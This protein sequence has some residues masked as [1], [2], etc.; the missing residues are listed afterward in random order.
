MIPTKNVTLIG[1][2]RLSWHLGPALENAHY[3][4]KEVYSRNRKNAE[5][6]VGR[7]YDAEVADTLDFAS[8]P[9][10]LFVLAV[11]DDAIASV[12]RELVLPDQ[13]ILV[14]TSGAKP[15]DV[16]D[17]AGTANTGVFYP[18]Q[19]FSKGHKVD[20]ESIPIFIESREPTVLG[21]LQRMARALSN[22]VI[23]IQS[24]QRLALHVAAVF[25]SN[26]TNHML[27]LSK[28]I[29]SQNSLDY[30]WMHPLIIETINKSLAQG[31]AAAQTGPARRRDLETLDL[32]YEFLDADPELRELYR[33][34][35]QHIL[36]YYET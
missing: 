5:A 15:L 7:L 27:S 11:S 13:S 26:F 17:F 36:D 12:A 28:D 8:S 30:Q 21:E 16:L 3:P 1:S 34:V 20:F 24:R 23:P 10:N 14:H 29:M 2:G 18:L 4:V 9:S 33:E 35:S 25:A 22:T 32:H 19:T 6:L 31:P